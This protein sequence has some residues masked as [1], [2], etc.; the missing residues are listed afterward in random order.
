V[1]M[2]AVEVGFDVLG[3]RRLSNRAD[4]GYYRA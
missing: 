4:S 3:M 1:A 2:R